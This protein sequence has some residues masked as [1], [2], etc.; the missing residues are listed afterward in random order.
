MLDVFQ[1]WNSLL[2][3]LSLPVNFSTET[4]YHRTAP[5]L[6][7][8]MSEEPAAETQPS[9]KDATPGATLPVIIMEKGAS[10]ASN[11]KSN[12]QPPQS[13]F[14]DLH[15]DPGKSDMFVEAT[16]KLFRHMVF[17]YKDEIRT[18]SPILDEYLNIWS[19]ICVDESNIDRCKIENLHM[20]DLNLMTFLVAVR[21]KRD[22]LWLEFNGYEDDEDNEEIPDER[23]VYCP[24]CDESSE[25]DESDDLCHCPIHPN[26]GTEYLA[27]GI[28]TNPWKQGPANDN[29]ESADTTVTCSAREIATSEIPGEENDC[30]CPCATCCASRGL[31]SDDDSYVLPSSESESEDEIPCQC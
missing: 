24:N 12:A 11:L 4:I 19:E 15:D 25:E 6:L 21:E 23:E 5:K 20:L 9:A 18:L 30:S 3:P 16:L 26:T 13:Q 29:K 28:T 10:E 27:C 7:T 1:P 8:M 14:P 2:W 17:P 22:E 31:D